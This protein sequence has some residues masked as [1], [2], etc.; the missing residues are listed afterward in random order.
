MTE[1][2]IGYP[3][4]PLNGSSLRGVPA[5]G[6]RVVPAA[7]QIPAGAGGAPLFALFAERTPAV[8]DLLRQLGGLLDREVRRPVREG[9]IL[10]V[11]PDGYAACAADRPAVIAGYLEGLQRSVGPVG[12]RPEPASAAADE[13][14]RKGLWPSCSNSP[15]K[16]WPARALCTSTCW[17]PG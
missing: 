9:A 16:P 1:V 7:D 6:E 8:A 14:G 15:A 10:L 11:R 5:P 4:S 17:F 2:S 13:Q 3:A 12:G